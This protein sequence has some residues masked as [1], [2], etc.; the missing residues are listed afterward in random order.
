MF[1]FNVRIRIW[2]QV[3]HFEV[4]ERVSKERKS[5]KKPVSSFVYPSDSLKKVTSNGP[6]ALGA[7]G[8]SGGSLSPLLVNLLKQDDEAS[9]GNKK[10]VLGKSRKG[11]ASLK[12]GKIHEIGRRLQRRVYF[13]NLV[14]KSVMQ[15]RRRS[16]LLNVEFLVKRY[17]LLLDA[18]SHLHL[19][20]HQ[21]HHH[22]SNSIPSKS[23]ADYMSAQQIHRNLLQFS[24]V[25][26]QQQQQLQKQHHL[27]GHRER[28]HHVV[29]GAS[30]SESEKSLRLKLRLPLDSAS[31]AASSSSSQISAS[32]SS[33][34]SFNSTS[35]HGTD[36]PDRKIPKLILSVKDKTIVKKNQVHGDA[37]G[38]GL[39]G[40]TITQKSK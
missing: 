37:G 7:V 20:Q 23:T 13:L 27:A 19:P 39:K 12:S 32:T 29:H 34:T 11:G 38:S 14:R 31:S 16:S 5:P 1:C 9:R 17:L 35:A 3:Y 15:E 6:T 26:R 33:A 24:S 10:L 21:H 36:S 28:N 2:P 25:L 4:P 8:A 22:N 30:E 40:V 18:T